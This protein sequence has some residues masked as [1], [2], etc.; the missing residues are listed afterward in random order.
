[1]RRSRPAAFAATALGVVYGGLALALPLT[2]TTWR[3][4]DSLAR[5]AWT[6]LAIPE[7]AAALD[8]GEPGAGLCGFTRLPKGD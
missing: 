3:Q 7:R 5:G 2:G 6:S 4:T 1:M 8:G